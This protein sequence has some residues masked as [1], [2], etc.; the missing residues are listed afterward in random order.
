MTWEEYEDTVFELCKIYYIDAIVSK[1]VKIVG[2]Y[3][4]VGRQIDI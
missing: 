2:R 1:N 4:K 3:S